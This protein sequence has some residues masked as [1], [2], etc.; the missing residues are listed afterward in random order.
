[1][2]GVSIG[3][4]ISAVVTLSVTG[5]STVA[6]DYKISFTGSGQSTSVSSVVV[7]NLTQG[8][9]VTLMG[10]EILHL[11]GTITGVAAT[12]AESGS[13]ITF[14]PNPMSELSVMNFYLKGTGKTLISVFDM[15][16]REIL[17]KDQDLGTGEHS[18]RISGLKAGMYMV[19]VTAGEE[20]FNGKLISSSGTLKSAGIDYI[21]SGSSNKKGKASKGS[22]AL[23]VM[24][25]SHGDRL[26][27]IGVSGNYRTLVVRVPESDAE[28]NFGFHA[29]TDADNNSYAVVEIGNQVWMAENLKTTKYNDGT[30]I[31][32]IQ[33]KL[34][35]LNL[36]RNYDIGY[37]WY[38]N[39]PDKYK[40]RYGALYNAWAV[41]GGPFNAK[42]VCPAGWHVPEEQEFYELSLLLD[43][44]SHLGQYSDI[45]GGKL[46]S[47]GTTYWESPNTGATN[48]VGFTAFPGGQR[49]V[50]GEFVG[51]G[52][53]GVWWSDK[54]LASYS[55]QYNSTTVHFS[56]G[57][58]EYGRSVR[59][60]KD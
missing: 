22:L 39:D 8:T 4:I 40:N 13:G 41:Y 19:R 5:I 53:S 31:P 54:G 15:S 35:W 18:F 47:S 3:K 36:D 29:C 44:D 60:I 43:P 6:Q 26:K 59:C 9:E 7:Q 51:V 45:A 25:Y 37:C 56:E 30:P 34:A 55:M 17:R 27:F 32:V 2:G 50:F 58:N 14:S 48:E 20:S 10:N 49:D 23:V 28:I 16:G 52:K 42:N 46:K 21:N 38:N 11:T 57:G 1:M 33:D 24:H 12:N